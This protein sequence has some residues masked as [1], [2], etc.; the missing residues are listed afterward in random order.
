MMFKEKSLLEEENITAAAINRL[1]NITSKLNT[2]HHFHLFPLFLRLMKEYFKIAFFMKGEFTHDDLIEKINKATLSEKSKSNLKYFIESML[3]FSYSNENITKDKLKK[4]IETAKLVVSKLNKEPTTKERQILLFEASLNKIKQKKAP[5]PFNSGKVKKK[6]S[7]KLIILISLLSVLILISI[8]FIGGYFTEINKPVITKDIPDIRIFENTNKIDAFDLDDFFISKKKLAYVVF[9]SGPIDIEISKENTVSM[10]PPK[11]WKG[12]SLVVF[13]TEHRNSFVYSNNVTIRVIK[14]GCGNGICETNETCSN[15][16]VDCGSCQETASGLIDSETGLMGSYGI[17]EPGEGISVGYITNL[18]APKLFEVP[19]SVKLSIT[20][21]VTDK[22]A[23]KKI[24]GTSIYYNQIK[25]NPI[26]CVTSETKINEN[27]TISFKKSEFERPVN[28]P[29]GYSVVIPEFNIECAGED[30]KVTLSAPDNYEEVKALKCTEDKCSSSTLTR[31]NGI[32][33]EDSYSKQ[34]ALRNTYI[35]SEYIDTDIKEADKEIDINPSGSLINI[36]DNYFTFYGDAGKTRIK[37]M[38]R[39]KATTLPKNPSLTLLTT[40]ILLRISKNDNI[41]VRVVMPYKP[42]ESIEESSIAVYLNINKT[43]WVYVESY[44]DENK[45]TVTADIADITNYL[46]ENNEVNIGLMG[47]L[48]TNC[49]NST[50][51]KAYQ[52]ATSSKDAVVLIHGLVSSPLTYQELL[53]DIKLTQQPWQVWVYGYPS[54]TSIDTNAIDF[55]NSLEKN[56][57]QYE[58]IY[59]VA[60][61]L[62]GLITQQALYYSYNEN[63]K[64]PGKYNYLKKVRKVILIGTPNRGSPIS[65]VYKDVFKNLVN[66]KTVYPIFN[67]NSKVIDDLSE[68]RIIPRVPDMRY[69]VIAGTKSYSF[70]NRFFKIAQDLYEDNDGIISTDSASFVGGDY[71]RDKGNDYWELYA[72]HTELIDI[73]E[74]RRVIESIIADNV[75]ENTDDIPIMGNNRY[76]ELSVTKC[77][78]SDDYLVIGKKIIYKT[79]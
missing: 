64:M 33:C 10:S 32:K 75:I 62:G 26:P 73:F 60:H 9:N 69:Y 6:I 51:E 27:Y 2:H 31:V 36:D 61:S 46:D 45:K 77:S 21:N 19:S 38:T 11:D 71:I 22:L 15:C 55:A 23:G 13:R 39:N 54:S 37:I 28:I 49:V 52:P 48:C 4:L 12:T 34:L 63:K 72:S 67:V 20:P 41:S 53:D 78:S 74:A 42:S 14:I 17:I 79:T 35:N 59:I 16:P 43:E 57:Q 68:G 8:I 7:T 44:I 70:T 65:E 25:I 47:V 76:F 30:I 5:P 40:P 50:F 66:V 29:Q 3:Y 24:R 18:Y 1:D 56:Q 58:N